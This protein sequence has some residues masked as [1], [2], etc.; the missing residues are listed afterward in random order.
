MAH[1]A[2]RPAE[3]V[4]RHRVDAVRAAQEC[5]VAALDAALADHVAAVVVVEA[6]ILE[7]PRADLGE[8]AVDVRA[9]RAI[10]VVAERHLSDREPSEDRGVLL[11]VPLELDVDVAREHDRRD[12]VQAQLAV[13]PLPERARL[14]IQHLRHAQQQVVPPGAVAHGP[15]IEVELV[16]D[17]IAY[18]YAALAVEDLAARRA[19][20]DLLLVVARGLRHERARVQHLQ[21]PEPQHEQQEEDDDGH[22][23]R[24]EPQ[25]QAPLRAQRE[26]GIRRGLRHPAPGGIRAARAA[27]TG[28][29]AAP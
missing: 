20:H 2:R 29:A 13:D 23:E 26:G 7:L 6:R 19:H 22:A 9:E 14:E 24:A 5:V 8:L 15:G 4:D 17:A 27:G 3:R 16:G 18:Q 1:G 25:A 28:G 21:R 10:R 11:Q 12:G